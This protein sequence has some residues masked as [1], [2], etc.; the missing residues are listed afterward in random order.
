MNGIIPILAGIFLSPAAL[1]ADDD[2]AKRLDDL[3]RCDGPVSGLTQF[4][5]H[6][7]A[8]PKGLAKPPSFLPHFEGQPPRL[9]LAPAKIA[10]PQAFAEPASLV[11]YYGWPASPQT[12]ELPTTALVALPSVDVNKPPPLPILGRPTNDRASLADATM[13]ASVAAALAGPIPLRQKA[14]PFVPINLPDPFE[15]QQLI[16]LAN[17]PPDNAPPMAMPGRILQKTLPI[18]DPL[19]KK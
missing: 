17:P 3:L 4:P 14:V 18:P 19:P 16:R 5:P 11:L 1:L 15:L 13:E 10:W 8:E 12:M 7:F 6:V 2:T 9:G